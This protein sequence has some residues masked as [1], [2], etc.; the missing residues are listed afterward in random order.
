MSYTVPNNLVS[1]YNAGQRQA[2]PS[3]ID[4]N[5]N[6][7]TN[8]LDTIDTLV[9]TAAAEGVNGIAQIATQAIAQAGMDDSNKFLNALKGKYLV[10]AL[11]NAVGNLGTSSA[12]TAPVSWSDQT[13]GGTYYVP[14][15]TGNTGGPTTDAYHLIIAKFDASNIMQLAVPAFSGGT[16]CWRCKI[17]GTWGSWYSFYG[18]TSELRASFDTSMLGFLLCN[19]GAYSRTTYAALF[20][21]LGTSFGSG[22]GSTTFNLPDFRGRTIQG[23]NA[24][25]KAVLAAGLPNFPGFTGALSADSAIN[26][27]FY[28]GGNIYGFTGSSYAT[29]LGTFFDPSRVSSIYGA[30]TTV[31]P[32]AIA[33]NIF[34]KY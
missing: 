4:E 25:L 16:P 11:V 8:G 21:I 24:N 29:G 20:A 23:A 2:D 15:N 14:S 6:Y 19:G 3:K 7:C 18:Y 32:P 33:T 28:K 9:K 17:G 5:F 12:L 30:S 10:Q 34:I 31:Q 1:Q 13:T 26:G 22:D 27:P